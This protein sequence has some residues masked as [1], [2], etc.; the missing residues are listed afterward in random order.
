MDAIKKPAQKL[1]F[2]YSLSDSVNVHAYQITKWDSLV[3]FQIATQLRP[4]ML[5]SQI[6]IKYH[7]FD[8][9][10]IAILPPPVVYR[11]G[12]A[13]FA[14]NDRILTEHPAKNRICVAF[15]ERLRG[16][17]GPMTQSRRKTYPTFHHL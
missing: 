17:S 13:I 6:P 1:L 10:F 3:L 5:L 11:S 9:H 15:S 12:N 4:G 2:V 8:K 7:K 16:L 14:V